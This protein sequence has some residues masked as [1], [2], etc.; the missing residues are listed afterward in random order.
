VSGGRT[1]EKAAKRN[2]PKTKANDALLSKLGN[3]ELGKSCLYLK[4]LQGVD[5]GVLARLIA[6]SVAAMKERSR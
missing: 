2:G 4:G 5:E 1:A 3:H 6:G